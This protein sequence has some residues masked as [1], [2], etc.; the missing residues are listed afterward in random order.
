LAAKPEGNSTARTHGREATL[1]AFFSFTEREPD[2]KLFDFDLPCQSAETQTG[3]M[4]FP[5]RASGCLTFGRPSAWD[6]AS[7]CR[8]NDEVPRKSMK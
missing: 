3:G 1:R 5:P 6:K 2:K 8:I 7:L 4:G